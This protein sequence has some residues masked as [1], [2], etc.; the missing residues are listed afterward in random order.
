MYIII[1]SKWD[2]PIF[3]KKMGR[4]NY[5]EKHYLSFAGETLKECMKQYRSAQE[6]NDLNLFLP[7]QID[8]VE[9]TEEN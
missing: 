3:S 1:A 5:G 2:R 6:N 8:T 9:N 7:M 4:M